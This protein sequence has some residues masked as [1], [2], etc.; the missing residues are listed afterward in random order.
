MSAVA[1]QEVAANENVTFTNTSVKGSNCIQ[2][3]VGSGIITLRGLTNQCQARFFVGFSANIALP[4]GGTVAPISLAI[5][6]SGEPVLA[7]KMISTPLVF[8]TAIFTQQPRGTL[9]K[10]PED[11]LLN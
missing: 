5:A 9:I 3:R 4:A 10:M 8:S 1:T 2:H 6:I 7:S 11:T